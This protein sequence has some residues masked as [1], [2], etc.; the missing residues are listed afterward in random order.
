M[1][2]LSEL[3]RTSTRP[4]HEHAETRTFVTDLMGGALDSAAYLDL[5]RQHYVIYSALEGAAERFAEDPFVGR[6]VMPE[7]L[8]L[9]R[10]R[11]DLS[12]LR[13]PDW[14]GEVEPLAST[15]VYAERLAAM[16]EPTHFL[17]HAYTRYLGDLSGG[18]AIA[19]MLRRHYGFTSRELTFYSFDV[20]KVKLFKDRYREM[21]DEVPFDSAQ[22]QETAA[23]AQVAFE[24]NSDVFVELSARHP[25]RET[26]P[27]L[28]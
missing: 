3:L 4:Q 21:M 14:E 23:E 12:S 10:L 9:D 28:G 20:G 27:T 25:A 24:L 16:S 17:A 7:I 1:T 22:A 8:R 2:P 5:A 13:G 15:Q 11:A 18:Q 6:F 26:A 19:A